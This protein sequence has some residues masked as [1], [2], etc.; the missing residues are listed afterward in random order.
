MLRGL[1]SDCKSAVL[2]VT[3]LTI[4]KKLSLSDAFGGYYGISHVFPLWPLHDVPNCPRLA[5][6]DI[7]GVR[8]P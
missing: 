1:D 8:K 6:Q 4:S 2:W 5:S 3:G 7:K